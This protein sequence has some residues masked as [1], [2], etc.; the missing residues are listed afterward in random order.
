MKTTTDQYWQVQAEY[1]ESLKGRE[2]LTPDDWKR[3]VYETLAI[4][5]NHKTPM[6]SGGTIS[7]ENLRVVNAHLKLLIGGIKQP[8]QFRVE[9][10]SL[11]YLIRLT[12]KIKKVA[13]KAIIEHNCQDRKFVEYDIESGNPV[14]T[15]TRGVQ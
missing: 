2:D 7:S 14:E 9:Q 4:A 8:E 5:L 13:Q 12:K 1:M 15:N 11:S 3:I 10:P 6:I